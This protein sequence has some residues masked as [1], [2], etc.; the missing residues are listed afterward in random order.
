MPRKSFE[1][2]IALADSIKDRRLEL[3]MTIEEAANKANVGTKTWSRYEAG[4]SIRS[5]KLRGVLKALRWSKFPDDESIGDYESYLEEYKAHSCWSDTIAINYGDL[6]AISFCIGTDL[7]Y[8]DIRMDIEEISTMPKNTHIGELTCSCLMGFLPEIYLMEYNY[9]FLF[10]LMRTFQNLKERAVSGDVFKA[11]NVAEEILMGIIIEEARIYIEEL[12]AETNFNN[13]EDYN[14]WKD[15]QYELLEDD[16]VDLCFYSDV[17]FTPPSEYQ[18]SNWFE[19]IFF[20][21]D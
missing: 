4:E 20:I 3:G 12:G 6:A 7:L 17:Y 9:E 18:F 11:H 21:N 5:D 8:D 15:W 16:D 10:K 14:G 19:N 2:N 13:L 1:N